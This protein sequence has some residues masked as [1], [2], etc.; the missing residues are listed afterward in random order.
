MNISYFGLTCFRIQNNGASILIDPYEDG[1]GLKL[2]R[3]QN[4]L[5][6][7]TKTPDKAK[8][9]QSFVITVPGEYEVKDIFIYALPVAANNGL[10]EGLI[11]L[12]ETE[13][14]H[15]VHLGALKKTKF[16]EKQLE[17]LENLD[18]LMVPVGGDNGLNAEQASELVTQLEPRLVIPMN[19]QLPGLKAKLEPLDKFKKIIGGKFETVDKLKISRKDLPEE[20]TNFFVIE[21]SNKE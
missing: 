13:G 5:T 16:N 10:S 17:R 4:D 7:Y 8:N 18:V 14:I 20:E 15:L 2:P 11:Y 12:I 9:D 6:L 21:A 3:M 1:V 19:Y